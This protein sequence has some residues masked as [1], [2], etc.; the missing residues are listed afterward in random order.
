MPKGTRTKS[1]GQNALPA[2]LSSGEVRVNEAEKFVGH[3][4]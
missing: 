1:N 3:A 2:K 4:L